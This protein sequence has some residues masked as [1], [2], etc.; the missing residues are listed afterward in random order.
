[1]GV[2]AKYWINFLK[3]TD[4]LGTIIHVLYGSNNSTKRWRFCMDTRLGFYN[5]AQEPD[6]RFLRILACS[7]MHNTCEYAT[8]KPL[9]FSI[10]R[11]VLNDQ[12]SHGG[13]LIPTKY[14]PACKSINTRCREFMANRRSSKGEGGRDQYHRLNGETHRLGHGKICKPD[15]VST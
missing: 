4:V 15:D 10:G 5:A 3:V 14:T 7:C 1:M 11:W 6:L 2:L 13:R 9:N 12:R 8:S